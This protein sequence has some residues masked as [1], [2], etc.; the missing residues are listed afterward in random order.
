MEP[1]AGAEPN[2]GV[3]PKAGDDPKAGA[4]PNADWPLALF[5]PKPELDEFVPN[6]EKIICFYPD[7]TASQVLTL[8]F[9][10]LLFYYK[11]CWS[12]HNLF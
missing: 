1:N 2:D 4:A 8:S 10:N 3:E 7:Y 5:P 12:H 11:S 9:V 6:P